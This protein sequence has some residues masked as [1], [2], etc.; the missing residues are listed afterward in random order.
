M[1]TPNPDETNMRVINEQTIESNGT[2]SSRR[3]QIVIVAAV[4]V[5]ALIIVAAAFFWL[6]PPQQVATEAPTAASSTG[7]V[8]FL[9]EQQWLIHMKLVQAD[10]QTVARQV[11]AT[12]RVVP[13]ANSQALVAPPVS[14]ILSGRNLPRVG[15]HVSQGQTIALIQQTATS[16]EQ[17]Q[18]QAAAASVNLENARLD[19]D[20]RTATG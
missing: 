10:E 11:T 18:V 6:R 15:Q 4:G 19:A 2:S 5:V 20:R 17:A 16:A 8:K 3:R 7:T 13:A 14:G 9:M 12:G 1:S